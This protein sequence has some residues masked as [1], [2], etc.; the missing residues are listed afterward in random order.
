MGFSTISVA[1][2]AEIA[3]KPW[4]TGVGVPREFRSSRRTFSLCTAANRRQDRRARVVTLTPVGRQ[5]LRRRTKA[6]ELLGGVLIQPLDEPHHV[7]DHSLMR[8]GSNGRDAVGRFD[9]ELD[10]ATIDFGYFGSRDDLPAD[11]RGR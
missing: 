10:T 4:L 6:P 9:L 5:K 7:D 3:L 2:S 8:A 11:R 1:R